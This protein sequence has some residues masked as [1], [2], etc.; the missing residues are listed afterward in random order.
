[1]ICYSYKSSDYKNE[2]EIR[3]ICYIK[4]EFSCWSF[5]AANINVRM[6]ADI[7]NNDPKLHLQLEK[8]KYLYCREDKLCWEN[9]KKLNKTSLPGSEIAA[10]A[11]EAGSANGI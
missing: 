6:L 11:A 9:G 3:L 8:G 5:E 2:E 1:M 4:K 10:C 7:D